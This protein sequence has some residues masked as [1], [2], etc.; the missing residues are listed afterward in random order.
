MYSA[1]STWFAKC[2]EKKSMDKQFDIETAISKVSSK[3]IQRYLEEVLSTYYNGE[4]RS[5]IVMLYATT[6]ADALE[7]IKVLSEV[8]QN[9]KASK[10]IEEYETF[11]K[12][13]KPY[14][15]LERKVKEFIVQ[16][17]LIN[18]VEEKQWEHLKDYRDF[19]AHPVVEEGMELISPN[20]E[21]VRMHIRNMFDALFLKD[22]ILT[23]K[24]IFDEF[25]KKIESFYD[26]NGV[27]ELEEYVNTRYISKL[28]ISTKYKFIKYL[29]KMTFYINNEECDKYRRIA[30]RSLIWIIDSDKSEL[31]RLISEEIDWFN[32]KIDFCEFSID[33]DSKKIAFYENKS[34]ALMYVLYQIQELYALLSKDNQTEIKNIAK[35][36]INLMLVAPYIYETKQDHI[37]QLKANLDGI[38]HCLIPY[39][40]VDICEK[41]IKGFDT[42][43]NEL[44]TYYFFK[45][46]NSSKWAPDW[47]YFNGTYRDIVS[48][49]IQYYTKE[50]LESFLE[51]LTYF[52]MNANCFPK[53]ASQIVDIS[54]KKGFDIDFSEYQIDFLK[55]K[56]DEENVEII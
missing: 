13:R 23:D 7:K 21:Q 32:G 45:C 47:D 1:L 25:L 42:G 27:E 30:Y 9:E 53:L 22:A 8:Y 55:Y 54:T 10:F 4:Y 51:Q 41:A 37:K 15:E 50:Q 40:V 48:K 34:F 20:G 14:S 43:Y 35:K 38:N 28:N 39:F 52:Y 5:C 17:G 49:T 12:D 6:F 44:I 2:I 46:Q 18:D 29:W 33:F 31:L 3:R 11:R 16:V 24:K 26:R 56:K 36:N 19:C